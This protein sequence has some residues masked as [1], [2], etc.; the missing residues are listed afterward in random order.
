MDRIQIGQRV[1]VIEGRLVHYRQ[2]G[3]VVAA[4]DG[5]W[6]VHL[7]YD[8]D[9]PDARIF[10]HSEELEAAPEA[11]LPPQRAAHWSAGAGLERRPDHGTP[12]QAP[13]AAQVTRVSRLMHEQADRLAEQAAQV[14]EQAGE[15]RS[16][17]GLLDEQADQLRNR[18]DRI[19][20]Q[21][22]QLR[23]QAEPQQP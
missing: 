14:D 17:A 20:E 9:R 22:D 3:T 7:D 12:A 4:G 2:V 23:S 6:Y 8:A 1:R 15:A 11:P 19:H 18:A 10:F 16:A 13:T 5:G 21:A